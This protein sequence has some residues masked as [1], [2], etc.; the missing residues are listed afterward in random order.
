MVVK[1]SASTARR[2]SVQVLEPIVECDIVVYCLLRTIAAIVALGACDERFPATDRN[3]A[4]EGERA[5]SCT[6]QYCQMSGI[7]SHLPSPTYDP[8]SRY[9][10]MVKIIPWAHVHFVHAIWDLLKQAGESCSV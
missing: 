4:C 9:L 10:H 1:A 6:L 5:D 3:V 7:E 8:S 2:R